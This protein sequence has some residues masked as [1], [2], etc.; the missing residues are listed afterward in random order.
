MT[1]LAETTRFGWTVDEINARSIEKRKQMLDAGFTD[2]E[3]ANETGVGSSNFYRILGGTNKPKLSTITPQLDAGFSPY[4]QVGGS[5]GRFNFDRKARESELTPGKQ[6]LFEHNNGNNSWFQLE[7]DYQG[8]RWEEA[9][10]AKKNYEDYS[11][12]PTETR[13]ALLSVMWEGNLDVAEYVNNSVI[14]GTPWEEVKDN[15]SNFENTYRQIS[16]TDITPESSMSD[17]QIIMMNDAML[18]QAFT[19]D[20]FQKIRLYNISDD[21]SEEEKQYF[22]EL[23]KYIEKAKDTSS[24][25]KHWT[26]EDAVKIASMQSVIGLVNNIELSLKGDP[27]SIENLAQFF[28]ATQAYSNQDWTIQRLFDVAAVVSDLPIMIPAGWAAT[29]L[30]SGTA[31]KAASKVKSIKGKALVGGGITA[32]CAM[33]AAFGVPATIRTVYMDLMKSQVIENETDFIQ[34]LQHAFKEGGKEFLVGLL[35]GGA[36]AL[37]KYALTS[38]GISGKTMASRAFI[39]GTSLLTETA[40]MSTSSSFIHTGK[41][42]TTDDFYNTLTVLSVLKFSNYSL[43]SAG[44]GVKDIQRQQKGY[45]KKNLERMY[46]QY[47]IDPRLVAEEIERNP[48]LGRELAELLAKNEFELHDFYLTH[49]TEMYQRMERV[50]KTTVNVD[51]QDV[52]VSR[53]FVVGKDG[54]KTTLEIMAETV[55]GADIGKASGDID[56]A[57]GLVINIDQTSPKPGKAKGQYSKIIFEMN[58]EGNW[59]LKDFEGDINATQIKAIANDA[60]SKGRQIITDENFVKVQE[61]IN[62]RTAEGFKPEEVSETDRIVDGILKEVDAAA[63]VLEEAGEHEKA[64]AVRDNSISL[65]EDAVGKEYVATSG[66]KIEVFNEKIASDLEQIREQAHYRKTGFHS[67]DKVAEK[68]GLENVLDR[69]DKIEFEHDG[70]ETEVIATHVTKVSD[71]ISADAIPTENAY[72]IGYF[73]PAFNSSIVRFGTDAQ[74]S[75]LASNMNNPSYIRAIVKYNVPLDVREIGKE[76]FITDNFTSGIGIAELFYRIRTNDPASF[77]KKQYESVKSLPEG[78]QLAQAVS[79]LKSKGY[80][81]ILYKDPKTGEQQVAI[82]KASNISV[83][84][85]TN[86]VAVKKTVA[87]EESKVELEKTTETVDKYVKNKNI[88]HKKLFDLQKVTPDIQYDFGK[89]SI[90]RLSSTKATKNFAVIKDG[91]R[92]KNDA[93]K[94][95]TFSTLKNAKSRIERDMGTA[96]KQKPKIEE[97][98]TAVAIREGQEASKVENKGVPNFMEL[99][100]GE[101]KS[102]QPIVNIRINSEVTARMS[103]FTNIEGGTGRVSKGEPFVLI[104]VNDKKDNHVQYKILEDGKK[105]VITSKPSEEFKLT[106]WQNRK[107]ESITQKWFK[108][109]RAE[110]EQADPINV[111]W[112]SGEEKVTPRGFASD[113][114]FNMQLIKGSDSANAIMTLPAVVEII[115]LLK[116][117]DATIH[118]FLGEGVRGRFQAKQATAGVDLVKRLKKMGTDQGFLDSTLR[119]ISKENYLVRKISIEEILQTDPSFREYVEANK[120][121]RSYDVEKVATVRP[122]MSAEGR[123]V[124]GYNRIHEAMLRGEK[125]I[126]VFKAASEAEILSTAKIK[127]IADMF[128]DPQQAA[129]LIA[130]ELGHFIDWYQGQTEFTLKR[131]NILGHLGGLKTYLKEY[132]ES[133]PGGLKPLNKNEKAKLKRQAKKRIEEDIEELSK[134]SEEIGL[135]PQQIK[136]IFTGVLHKGEI[137]PAIWL[138]IQKA[139]TKIK[140]Q[141]LRSAAKGEVYAEIKALES[142][143]KD[144]PSQDLTDKINAKYEEMF[145]AE[146]EARGLL[147]KNVVGDELKALTTQWRPF[148]P[149][150]DA[151]YTAYRYSN[152]ELY[153]DFFSAIMTNPYWARTIAP[154]AYEGFFNHMQTKPALMKLYNKIQDELSSGTYNKRLVKETRQGYRDDDKAIMD[155][156]IKD[157]NLIKGKG[158]EFASEY[159]DVFWHTISHVKNHKGSNIPD[160]LNPI[161]KFDEWRYAGSRNE[162]YMNA[163]S[164]LI[165]HSMRK[166]N[167]S[168]TDMDEY[169]MHRRIVLEKGGV[170]RGKIANN[171]GWYKEISQ[172]RLKELEAAHPGLPELAQKF[173]DIRKE[174]VVDKLE[175]S[176]IYDPVLMEKVRNN[177]VYATF[178][179]SEYI[180]N[181]YGSGTSVKIFGQQGSFGNIA[182]PFT[183]TLINDLKL[184]KAAHMQIALDTTIGFYEM[185]SKTEPGIFTYVKAEKKW[186]GKTHEFI[187]PN[188]VTNKETLKQIKDKEVA[189]LTVMRNGKM[190][191]VYLDKHIVDQFKKNSLEAVNTIK[192]MRFVNQKFRSLFTEMNPGFWL[193][194]MV[195]DFFRTASN[196]EQKGLVKWIPFSQYVQYFPFWVK[197]FSSGYRSIYGIDK[198]INIKDY[199]LHMDEIVSAFAGNKKQRQVAFHDFREKY[200]V[201]DKVMKEMYK[202]NE[203]ISIEERWGDQK[204]DTEFERLLHRHHQSAWDQEINSKWRQAGKHFHNI[205]QALERQNKFGARM[206]IDKH[207]PNITPELRGHM[208]RVQVGSPAFLRQGSLNPIINNM[209]MFSNAIKEGVRGDYDVMRQRPGEWWY[210]KIQQVAVPKLLMYAAITGLL[211]KDNA[212]IMQGVSKYDLT[213][214]IIIPL[215]L[216]ENG[217]SVY[218]RVP[219]DETGRYFGGIFW[220]SIMESHSSDLS[221]VLD[222]TAGNLPAL[223]PSI[224]AAVDIAMYIGD[225]NPFDWFKDRKA[226][227]DTVWNAG[228]GYR[229]EAFAQHLSNKFGGGIVYRF[230]THNIDEIKGELEEQLNFPIIQNTIGRFLKVGNAGQGEGARSGE[231]GNIEDIKKQQAQ[232]TLIIYKYFQEVAKNPDNP[233][234][235]TPQVKEAL[236]A[237][238]DQ[239][240]RMSNRVMAK[241][242]GNVFFQ[243]LLNAS[244]AERPMMLDN[245]R[246]MSGQGNIE[247]KKF[248]ELYD[249][250]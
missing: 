218:F 160:H 243:E 82:L 60:E 153:A 170:E 177:N 247:A 133:E 21:M 19:K 5:D 204:A 216:D 181:K 151:S 34:I 75:F 102:K 164:N 208:I 138:F 95:V 111:K 84:G 190:E 42:P 41:P 115:R 237:K 89:Y 40:A 78:Q 225:N 136:D 229:R 85:F 194:N 214:Y 182:G 99:E 48:Q 6:Y 180:N 197:G 104:S 154:T 248:L 14:A 193:T 169:L 198:K 116:G 167:L 234:A 96:G 143:G 53:F 224:S 24:L 174:W 200:G 166:Q 27:D 90:V 209:F 175:A 249:L 46:A 155:S 140:K 158:G 47:G 119:E 112:T 211:G 63:K 86:R 144:K 29:K 203:L 244:N 94:D 83:R 250:E 152:A 62:K 108:D 38:A 25:E 57:T 30:C 80:D 235:M 232:Y 69:I 113:G 10:H 37:T 173:W 185:K 142:E 26:K 107:I 212:T 3:V 149:R 157:E 12:Y 226:I 88:T 2:Q 22:T 49:V 165:V 179:V 51:S 163:I 159:I 32:G 202:N 217:K 97:N 246:G 35:T 213:N 16:H 50:K 171:R 122:V 221:T 44:Q 58:R 195:R 7:Q 184:M 199:M 33:G 8:G 76:A 207:F 39:S 77:N 245:I 9:D 43:K 93:G 20:A 231:A 28:L 109:T 187:N 55:E 126:V 4:I 223:S 240:G 156:V 227:D 98:D 146:V 233:P 73:N 141:I 66:A 103:D 52:K 148:D 150:I 236:I 101:F 64:Q 91:K 65:L 191:G 68:Q 131:G 129:A 127:I 222:Y 242:Y 45:M 13:K 123:V 176:G 230:K 147:E 74:A 137:N 145:A 205:G 210:K 54:K 31:T 114:G 121:I 238:W 132:L 139:N 168:K 196:L 124:D 241:L 71:M 135:T 67:Q 130:H 201:P 1:T 215:G 70:V 36:G 79:I 87:L 162:G 23:N 106:F 92:L 220:S 239:L 61:I 120:E 219:L 15:L 228:D 134:D 172:E 17:E 206:Y 128:E 178:D 183:R 117:S 125:D 188:K 186:N 18:M 81:S 100:F 11:L 105:E 118:K 189:L 192:V 72:R 59:I 110:Q 56:K 161:Y